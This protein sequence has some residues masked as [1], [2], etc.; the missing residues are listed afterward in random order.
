MKT[1]YLENRTKFQQTYIWK[2]INYG[3]HKYLNVVI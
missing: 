2:E 1:M 3:L